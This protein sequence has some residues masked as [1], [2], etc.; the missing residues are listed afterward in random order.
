MSY[1]LVGKLFKK[2][3]TVARSEKFSTREF[4]MEIVDGNYNQYIGLQLINDRCSMLDAH[5]EG[6]MIKVHFDLRGREWQ[7]KFLT[8]LNA[9][10]ID[11][12][13][14]TA[15]AAAPQQ[16]APATVT[17]KPVVQP[18]GDSGFPTM[19]DAPVQQAEDDLPF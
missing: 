18:A 7:G 1:E 6:E 11:K 9:W 10:R 19:A 15:V 17:A 8:N 4:G 16:A 2:F 5:N 13:D 14:A 12:A 3:D